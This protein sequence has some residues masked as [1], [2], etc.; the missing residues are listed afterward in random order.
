MPPFCL[1]TLSLS[2]NL[3]LSLFFFLSFWSYTPFLCSLPFCPS[4]CSSHFDYLSPCLCSS[5]FYSLCYPLLFLDTYIWLKHN[6]NVVTT[7]SWAEKSGFLLCAHF[8]LI[9]KWDSNETV[10]R[11]KWDNEVLMRIKVHQ[12]LLYVFYIFVQYA[13]SVVFLSCMLIISAGKS[14]YVIK[15]YSA[16]KQKNQT[17]EY[18]MMIDCVAATGAWKPWLSKRSQAL[19]PSMTT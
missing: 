9:R 18:Q 19:Y 15:H 3:S 4:F 12:L 8:S 10:M 11:L 17:I 6:N 16:C 13:H 7:R 2:M 5:L 1:V 14:Q